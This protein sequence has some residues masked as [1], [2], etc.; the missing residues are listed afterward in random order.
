MIGIR[1]S[2]LCL[3]ALALGDQAKPEI[4]VH[5]HSES[6]ARRKRCTEFAR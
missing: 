4:L 1:F 6:E 5:R 2:T 3:L